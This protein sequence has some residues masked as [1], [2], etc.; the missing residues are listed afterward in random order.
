[1]L[2]SI[3]CSV[4][5]LTTYA[6]IA[7]AHEELPYVID[8]SKFKASIFDYGLYEKES[9]VLGYYAFNYA[10]ELGPVIGIL[11]RDY[12]LD[13]AIETGTHRGGTTAFFSLF[14]DEV[15]TIDI[16]EHFLNQT[17]EA[18]KSFNNIQ[19]HM[20]SSE[21][22]LRDLL[23]KIKNKIP[24]VY[25]DAHWG[26]FWP[27]LDEI[28]ELS[29][30]HKDN[31]VVIIDDFKVPGRNEIPYDHYGEHECSF[32]YVKPQIDK[33]FTEYSIHYLIPKTVSCRAKLV[34]TPKILKKS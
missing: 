20:G 18:L 15:H 31:C 6:Q 27:L 13:L 19:Y 32:E 2:K 23:P 5:A 1:M 12:K 14:F 8:F 24:L 17:K 3:A 9:L 11:K 33:L 30:T 7:S 34:V 26:A 4:I 16:N 10:P 28:E 21:T 22:V 29:K 25:L